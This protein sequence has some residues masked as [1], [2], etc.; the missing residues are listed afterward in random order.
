MNPLTDLSKVLISWKSWVPQ[1]VSY[2]VCL[3]FIFVVN[4]LTVCNGLDIFRKSET[5]VCQVSST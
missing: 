4:S 1:L 5:P 3:P 2:G